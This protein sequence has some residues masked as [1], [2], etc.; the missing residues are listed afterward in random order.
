MKKD[1]SS[2]LDR[3][4]KKVLMKCY[5]WCD[6]SISSLT[7][8]LRP[9]KWDVISVR[10][11]GLSFP[12]TTSLRIVVRMNHR[13]KKIFD[14]ALWVRV[15][16]LVTLTMFDVEVEMYDLSSAVGFHISLILL[17]DLFDANNFDIYSGSDMNHFFGFNNQV[18]SK[19]WVL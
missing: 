8:K 4:R 7:E 17:H 11:A 10:S 15:F 5:H 18:Q 16:S 3:H 9:W 12:T 6:R 19:Q 14:A 13:R 2:W 1:F